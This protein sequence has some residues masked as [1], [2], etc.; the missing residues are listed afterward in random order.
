M[1]KKIPELEK[2]Q[3][4]FDEFDK[5]I[6][7]M[8][9]ERM[10]QAPKEDA[11]PK[12][13]LSQKEIEKSNDIYLKPSRSIGSKEK[14]N[15]KFKD[16]YLFAKEYVRLIP[17]HREIVGEVIEMW[18]KPYPGMPAEFWEIPTGR[19]I[20]AP[21]YVAEQITKCRYHRFIMKDTVDRGLDQQGHRYYGGIA[22]DT[23]IQR[24]D[25]LPV[26]TRKSIFMGAL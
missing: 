21:R 18:T 25:A 5:N 4:Q 19:P 3:E 7:E 16:D 23:I 26:S 8:T 14:F 22:A 12:H 6:K 17:E 10:N 15:D 11:E 24:L 20:W 13:L 1:T 9:L 2:A